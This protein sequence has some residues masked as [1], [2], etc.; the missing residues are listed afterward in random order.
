[1]G[2]GTVEIKILPENLIAEKKQSMKVL[3]FDV[4]Q[5]EFLG[6][7]LGFSETLYLDSPPTE[8]LQMVC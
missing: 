5:C 6:S 2:N 4:M 1:M 3:T 7:R 8:T